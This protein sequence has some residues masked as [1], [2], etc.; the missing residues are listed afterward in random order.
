MLDKIPSPS[1]VPSPSPLRD[2]PRTDDPLPRDPVRLEAR[3]AIRLIDDGRTRQLTGEA[4]INPFEIGDIM[5]IYAP[6]NGDPAKGNIANEFD[7]NWKRYEVYGEHNFS[8]WLTNERQGWRPAL[9]E[10]FPGR[11]A[12]PGTTGMVRV[13]DMVLMQRPMR[14]TAQARA[15]EYAKANRAMQANRQVMAAT[16]EGQAPRVVLADR[17]AREA[18]EI[19]E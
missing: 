3:D 7:F 2:N 4:T 6:T 14:L 5:A 8:E 16:P 11:F 1:I 9:H 12:P 17:T 13:K 10:Q 18:I 19:P 15:E